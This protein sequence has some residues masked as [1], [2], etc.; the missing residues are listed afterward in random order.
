MPTLPHQDP[1]D[2]REICAEGDE[3]TVSVGC[4]LGFPGP[5]LQRAGRLRRGSGREKVST[6]EINQPLE[7][8][9]SCQLAWGVT[10]SQPHCPYEGQSHMAG[11]PTVAWDSGTESSCYGK[12]FPSASQLWLAFCH[13]GHTG[14]PGAQHLPSMVGILASDLDSLGASLSSLGDEETTPIHITL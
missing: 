10:T 12:T 8:K 14:L 6:L 4:H 5:R 3:P 11:L 2:M 9:A 7:N 13:R 1:A